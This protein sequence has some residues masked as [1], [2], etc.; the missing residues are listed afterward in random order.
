MAQLFISP[1]LHFQKATHGHIDRQP[2]GRRRQDND[3]D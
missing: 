1:S 3:R 2:E